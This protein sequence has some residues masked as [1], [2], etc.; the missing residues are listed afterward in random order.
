MKIVAVVVTYNRIELLKKNI[1]CLL[2]QSRSLDSIVVLDNN[3]SDGTNLFCQELVQRNPCIIYRRLETNTGGA[4]GF[5]E[6]IKCAIELGADYIW[7][8]DDDA[9]PHREALNELV[10][11]INRYPSNR[12]CLCSNTYFMDSN[13]ICKQIQY[14][15]E[16]QFVDHLT[17]VGFFIS[18]EIVECIGYPRKELFIYYDDLD[19]SLSIREAGFKIVGVGK[20]IIEHPYIMPENKH[21]IFF[22]KVNVPTMPNWKMYYW[23]R[24]NLLIRRKKG[25]KFTR[26]AILELYVVVKLLIFKPGQVKIALKGYFDGM[27]NKSGKADVY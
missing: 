24:N 27:T 26:A 9:M 17:F 18:K 6:A 8:M 22:F 12:Y 20:S 2:G 3:S 25:R 1:A 15:K 5:S 16:E 23:M 4:G 21:K 7:G 19:Y 10:K 14:S 11:S 13:G